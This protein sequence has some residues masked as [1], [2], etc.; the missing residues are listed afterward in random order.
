MS[1][2]L[3][4]LKAMAEQISVFARTIAPDHSQYAQTLAAE[5][6]AYAMLSSAYW[7]D[8]DLAAAEAALDRALALHPMPGWR[9]RRALLL[10]VVPASR[11][12]ILAARDRLRQNLILL[13]AEDGPPVDSVSELSWTLFLLAYHAEQ[14]NQSLHRLFHYVLRRRDRRLDWT[15]PHCRGERRPGKKRVGFIS[16]HFTDHTISRLFMGMLKAVDRSRFEVAIFSFSGQNAALLRD[17]PGDPGCVELPADLDRAQQSIAAFELDHLI[18]LDLGM[19]YFTLYLA[20]ARLAR[21]QVVMWGHP[22]TTGLDSIDSFLSPDCMEPEQEADSHYGERLICLPGPMVA[23]SRPDV[24]AANL[25]RSDLGLPESGLLY[26]CPQSP[27]KFHPDFD[28]ALIRILDGVENS[29]LVLAAGWEQGAMN[30][31]KARIVAQA[32]HLSGR[33]LILGPLP[34]TAFLSLFRQCDVV[35]D[36]FHYSGG[37]TSLEAFACAV[38]VVTWPGRFMRA[39]H[40]YGFYRL[41]DIKDGIAPDHHSYVE[42]AVA[43]GRDEKI[44]QGMTAKIKAASGVLFDNLDG[45]RALESVLDKDKPA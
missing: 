20:H 10:P 45:V 30:R 37:H 44:R 16:W 33:I 28:P 17:F 39:R 19:D 43:W 29:R 14:D 7:R 32:P 3:A 9:L 11:A 24:E 13:A 31:V 38:P 42:K 34:R 35:L 36:P 1:G 27:Y 2:Q 6:Q 26:L 23:Y 41:M 15:A 22:D 4:E 18:Y 40:T 8:G 5:A 21:H 25:S 12:E